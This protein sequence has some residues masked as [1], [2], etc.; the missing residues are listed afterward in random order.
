M[1]IRMDQ[2]H[3]LNPWAEDFVKGEQVFA[4]TERVVRVYPGDREDETQPDHDVYVSTIKMEESGEHYPGMF[5]NEYPLHKHTFPD[6][7]VYFERVQQIT[8]SSGPCIF[9]ALQDEE[10]EWISDSKWLESEIE[11]A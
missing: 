1:G 2:I 5:D 7:S 8:L 11:A 6:G 3:G 10:G 4:Y 9:L